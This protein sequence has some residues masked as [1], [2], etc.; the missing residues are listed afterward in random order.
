MKHYGDITKMNGAD[1][2]PVWASEI[3]PFC[4]RVTQLRFAEEVN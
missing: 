3:D 1:I 2:E 4:I